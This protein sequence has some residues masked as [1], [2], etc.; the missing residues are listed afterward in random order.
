[1]GDWDDSGDDWEA[2]VD[3]GA[4]DSKLGAGPAKS[5]W[6]D[7]DELEIEAPEVATPSAALYGVD[8]DGG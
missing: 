1:M 7:E 8:G 6:D 4:L 2:E 5:A 3:L